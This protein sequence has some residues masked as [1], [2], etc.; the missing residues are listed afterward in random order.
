MSHG[1]SLFLLLSSEMGPSNPHSISDFVGESVCAVRYGPSA[2]RYCPSPLRFGALPRKP[3][4]KSR[5]RHANSGG[6][7]QTASTCSRQRRQ[8]THNRHRLRAIYDSPEHS[9][10]NATHFPQRQM[11]CN[12]SLAHRHVIGGPTPIPLD[13]CS[14][15]ARPGGYGWHRPRQG[16]GGRGLPLVQSA[17]DVINVA[18]AFGCRAFHSGQIDTSPHHTTAQHCIPHAEHEPPQSTPVSSPFCCPS[19]HVAGNNDRSSEAVSG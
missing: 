7:Q 11:A 5:L 9:L 17:A 18:L 2:R 15:R 4:K 13:N 16:G 10:P 14:L 12:A 1:Q 19:E 3:K 8:L 6:R